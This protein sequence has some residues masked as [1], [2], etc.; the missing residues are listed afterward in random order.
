MTGVISAA[1]AERRAELLYA[2]YGELTNGNP[3]F[4]YHLHMDPTDP[5]TAAL[6]GGSDRLADLARLLS[7]DEVFHVWRLQLSHPQWWIGGRARGT[8]PLLARIISELSGRRDDGQH[9]LG[10]SGY[11]GAQW[12][13]K[14]LLAIA[15]LSAPARDKLTSAL[16]R[17]LIGRTMCQH[18]LSFMN[19]ISDRTFDAAE[20]F[21]EFEHVEPVDSCILGNAIYAVRKIHGE[22]WFEAFSE[23]VSEL[24]PITWAGLTEA[25]NVELRERGTERER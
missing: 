3:G 12:F 24:D 1:E 11:I 10:G 16:H 7:N 14:A 15:P 22:E 18:S 13:N 25:L 17:E 9:H 19:F 8:T 23:L 6:I 2:R 20:M 5:V 4:D 21:P